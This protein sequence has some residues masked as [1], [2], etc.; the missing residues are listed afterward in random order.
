MNY[1]TIAAQLV[2]L[3]GEV[4]EL[5]R[6]V[7]HEP[8]ELGEYP[9]AT[10]AAAAHVNAFQTTGGNDRRYAFTVRLYYRTDV[11]QDAETVLR[12]VTDKVIAKLEA[13]V[14][15]A[16]VWDIARPTEARWFYQEREVPVRVVELTVEFK[17]YVNR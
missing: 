16:N 4:S 11:A 12:D 8:K 3:L 15:V 17:K 2:T 6:V 7:N 5:N 13:N 1:V 10:V 9:C 14:T